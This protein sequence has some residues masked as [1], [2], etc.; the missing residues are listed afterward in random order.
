VPVQDTVA[1]NG[2]TAE[3]MLALRTEV[4]K[5]SAVLDERLSTLETQ[6]TDVRKQ[7]KEK[8]GVDDPKALE[9][10][11]TDSQGEVQSAVKNVDAAF[12]NL[13]NA[14]AGWP[15]A[16]KKKFPNLERIRAQWASIVRSGSAS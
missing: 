3:A 12:D 14:V 13:Q 2:K 7:A 10:M 11:F 4:E 1:I 15:E 9:K 16:V 5:E 8:F 6:M